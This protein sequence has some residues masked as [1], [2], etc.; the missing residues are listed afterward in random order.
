VRVDAQ[1][2]VWVVDA[3]A[4][5]HHEVTAPETEAAEGARQG[6]RIAIE[7]SARRDGPARRR[8]QAQPALLI[9]TGRPTS[10]GTP[11]NILCVSDR[12]TPGNFFCSARGEYDKNGNPSSRWARAATARTSSTT[13]HS[14]HADAPG[15][16]CY[17]GRSRQLAIVVLDNSTSNWSRSTTRSARRGRVHVAG[18]ASVSLQQRLQRHEHGDREAPPSRRNLQDGGPNGTV[19]GRFA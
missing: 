19:L 8:T 9:S 10:R 18:T 17:D 13:P 15:A 4:K 3:G 2:N 1:D 12:L 16:T 6:D 7:R 11:G 5:H 14:N